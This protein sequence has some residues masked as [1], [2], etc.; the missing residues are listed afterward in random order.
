MIASILNFF[1]FNMI[2]VL[3]SLFKS[4]YLILEKNWKILEDR[5]KQWKERKAQNLKARK[6]KERRE[7]DFLA[8]Y[9]EQFTT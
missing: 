3:K 2:I 6:D 1:F 7:R 5:I 4:F 9:E 8:R